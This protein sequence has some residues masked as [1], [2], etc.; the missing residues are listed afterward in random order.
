[1]LHV[2]CKVLKHFSYM[3]IGYILDCLPYFVFKY[4]CILERDCCMITKKV[5]FLNIC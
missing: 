5:L 3:L 1:M 2:L 4:L